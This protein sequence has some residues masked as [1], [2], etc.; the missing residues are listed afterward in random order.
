MQSGLY[1][2]LVNTGLLISHKE[3]S[4]EALG[5]DQAYKVIRPEVV[6]F[7]S[8]PY[9]WCF[10]QLKDAALATLSIQKKGA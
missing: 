10:S 2:D 3:V 1:E 6:P 7:I 9:E 8:Y 5:E 4:I